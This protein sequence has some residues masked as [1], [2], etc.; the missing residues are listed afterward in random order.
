MTVDKRVFVWKIITVSHIYKNRTKLIVIC[1]KRLCQILIIIRALYNG[2]IDHRRLIKANPC[3]R[4][5]VFF[6][7][8]VKINSKTFPFFIRRNGNVFNLIVLFPAG[9]IRNQHR[10]K[11]IQR[12]NKHAR[13]YNKHSSGSKI[14]CCPFLFLFLFW[15]RL[16]FSVRMTALLSDNS[17]C[18]SDRLLFC[19]ISLSLSRRSS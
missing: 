12:K 15:H 13:R 16:W 10:D 4:V 18:R 19:R 3:N 6:Q 17:I 2:I 9:V 8:S 14:K 5:F 7:Q 1:R 11:L